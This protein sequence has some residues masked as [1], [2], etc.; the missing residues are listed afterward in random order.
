MKNLLASHTKRITR[1]IDDKIEII[2]KN[3]I[4]LVEWLEKNPNTDPYFAREIK[5]RKNKIALLEQCKERVI[6]A[7]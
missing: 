7:N 1:L 2:E 5:A 6:K 3:L 4:H